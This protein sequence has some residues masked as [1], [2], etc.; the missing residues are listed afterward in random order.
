M[1]YNLTN[2]KGLLDAY[3][4]L[5]T[6][7]REAV[8][9]HPSNELPIND[10]LTADEIMAF[11]VHSYHLQSDLVRKEPSSHKRRQQALFTI[12]YTIKTAE[13][14]EKNPA[15]VELIVGRNDFVNR[16]ALHF[17]KFENS[18]DWI[19]LC[20]LQDIMDDVELTL[21]SESEGTDKK[22]AQEI[23]KLKLEIRE[24]ATKTRAE[25]R[26]LAINLFSNDVR[27]LDY[28]ASHM[29]LEKRTRIIS[30]ESYSAAYLEAAGDVDKI[31]KK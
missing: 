17:C 22:S 12:G 26:N 19:E 21:R 24:K 13:D 15:L 20:S 5:K 9:M 11:V 30:P 18:I 28:A 7:Y 4:D 6:I 23:L 14:I 29:I 27:L 31:F 10:F 3:P 8:S 16:L 1:R 25:M 2:I